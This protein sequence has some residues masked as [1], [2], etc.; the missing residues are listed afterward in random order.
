MRRAGVTFVETTGVE[1]TG[2]VEST[3]DESTSGVKWTGGV[4]STGDESTGGVESMGDESAGSG[5]G[6]MVMELA[7]VEALGRGAGV[8]GIAGGA[9]SLTARRRPLG[10]ISTTLDEVG[11]VAPN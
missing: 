1:W 2:G 4:K 7:S 6:V 10:G 8:A 11:A 5:A 3:G 9:R